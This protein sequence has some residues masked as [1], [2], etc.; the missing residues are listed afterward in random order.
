MENNQILAASYN[1]FKVFSRTEFPEGFLK[2]KRITTSRS[3][4][5]IVPVVFMPDD[6]NQRLVLACG[7]R[8][9]TLTLKELKVPDEPL[10]ACD[11]KGSKVLRTG[12]ESAL[13]V[14]AFDKRA[15]V[16][17][18]K[19]PAG[20]KLAGGKLTWTPTI[21]QVGPATASLEISSGQ[22]KAIQTV[23]LSV[24][25]DCVKL[26][27]IARGLGVSPDGSRAI[28]WTGARN[29]HDNTQPAKVALIDLA[30]M[31]I[32]VTKKLP[33]PVRTAAVDANFVY[34][35]PATSDRINALDLKDLS[36]KH[37]VLTDSCVVELVTIA[38]K[39]L[40]ARRGEHGPKVYEVPKLKAADSPV[41]F[42]SAD[43][44]RLDHDEAGMPWRVGDNWYAAGCLFGPDLTTARML[45]AV[46]DLHNI[47]EDER[48]LFRPVVPL[49]WNR[50][51]GPMDITTRTGQRIAELRLSK[52]VILPGVPVAASLTSTFDRKDYGGGCGDLTTVLT[53]RDLVSGKE[54]RKT[55]LMSGVLMSSQL[56]ED[57]SWEFMAGFSNKVI[58]L[59]GN[60]I[61]V[62]TVS[63]ETL[64]QC[65]APFDFV[66]LEKIPVLDPTKQTIITHKTVGGA[67]PVEFELLGSQKE[68][69]I[70]TKTGAVTV[71][72]PAL[73]KIA[74]TMA[75]A[76]V[77]SSLNMEIPDED[78]DERLRE[79]LRH[80]RMRD[81]RWPERKP[82]QTPKQIIAQILRRAAQTYKSYTGKAPAGISVL[83][84]V[85]VA[86]TD[87]NQQVASMQYQV[88]IDI[89]QADIQKAIDARIAK[90]KKDREL[91]AKQREEMERKYR[92]EQ[93][94]RRAEYEAQREAARRAATQPAGAQTG[95]IRKL[96]QRV[97]RLEAKMDMII[98]LLRKQQKE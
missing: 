62:H 17:L 42:K 93:E 31:K 39:R 92:A 14:S 56:Y 66:P 46:S 68:L 54:V 48:I 27:L 80:M 26:A 4:R 47:T 87:K 32:L 65:P 19:G 60:R 2:A 63:A 83:V 75:S 9:M 69:K 81:R 6:A 44:M 57:A 5:S 38:S 21:D 45:V 30:N 84:P 71:D 78:D 95:E 13:A 50:I 82:N 59:A 67:K 41:T 20:M 40:V 55:L 98:E 16:R 3:D 28:V 33:Y 73:A 43:D 29:H 18:A 11:V 25:R 88:V 15:T 52:T 94:R 37:F 24:S 97:E 34:V 64:K 86:A 89:P 12:V 61:F 90:A 79:A 1:T 76:E 74:M 49:P 8:I 77:L 72:S 58:A 51:L 91:A 23:N 85:R 10:L 35:A 7:N 36:R 96:E 22:M 70:N 53:L